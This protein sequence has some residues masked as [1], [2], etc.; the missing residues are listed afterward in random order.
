V[1]EVKGRTGRMEGRMEGRGRMVYA[2]G[3]VYDGGWLA[4]AR[5]GTGTISHIHGML[6]HGNW[7]NN[8]RHGFGTLYRNKDKKNKIL[9]GY[10]NEGEFV[11][12]LNSYK[13]SSFPY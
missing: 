13:Q 7:K 1:G 4:D 5:H 2:D 8:K 10:W 11:S 9:E 12:Q 6:F 3:T